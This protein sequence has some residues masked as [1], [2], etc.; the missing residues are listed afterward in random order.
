MAAMSAAAAYTID[1]SN[2]PSQ[3]IIDNL[4]LSTQSRNA[5]VSLTF[6]I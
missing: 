4:Q 2:E 1:T 6:R 3:I 5:R